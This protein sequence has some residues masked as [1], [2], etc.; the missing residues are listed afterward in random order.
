[1]LRE[2]LIKRGAAKI[3]FQIGALVQIFA[4]NFRYRQTVPAKVAGKFEE[5]DILLTH[6]IQNSDRA[7]FAAAAIQPDDLA[8]RASEFALQRLHSL[9]RRVEMLFE[10]S[11]EDFHELRRCLLKIPSDTRAS[12][13]RH[14]TLIPRVEVA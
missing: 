8:P 3:F 6:V 2:K 14:M 1:M 7:D 12:G 4:I 5:G 13:V 9:N 11:F 10:K